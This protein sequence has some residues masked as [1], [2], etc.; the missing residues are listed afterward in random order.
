MWNTQK[1]NWCTL[2]LKEKTISPQ[3]QIFY[4]HLYAK[5]VQLQISLLNTWY[6]F[7]S[8]YNRNITRIYDDWLN[9]PLV[10]KAKLKKKKCIFKKSLQCNLS[11]K[12]LLDMP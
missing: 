11:D 10:P 6:Q 1:Q 7:A 8:N 9:G 5:E 12:K 3:A 4:L 2:I